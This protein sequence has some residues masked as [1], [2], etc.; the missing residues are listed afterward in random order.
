MLRKVS[1]LH[2][3]SRAIKFGFSRIFLMFAYDFVQV[4]GKT[5][6]NAR[7]ERG[8]NWDQEIHLPVQAHVRPQ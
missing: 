7:R 1:L 3:L 4:M 8:E 6:D 2:S 5:K